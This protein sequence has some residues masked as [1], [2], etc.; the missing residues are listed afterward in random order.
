MSSS[1]TGLLAILFRMREGLGHFF[2]QSWRTDLEKCQMLCLLFSDQEYLSMGDRVS[3]R[4]RKEPGDKFNCESVC[5]RE[6]ARERA[7]A[8]ECVCVCVQVIF[9]RQI[10]RNSIE[11]DAKQTYFS[12]D[13]NFLTASIDHKHNFV[14]RSV[15]L[16]FY[17]DKSTRMGV[18]LTNKLMWVYKKYLFQ[19]F[20]FCSFNFRS[21][22]FF[23]N[24]FLVRHDAI[25][26]IDHGKSAASS[27]WDYPTMYIHPA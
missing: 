11:S 19:C 1:R 5:E 17:Y 3:L 22:I 2:I 26:C 27:I 8:R 6:S 24:L 21:F 7:F 9:G 13:F 14:N 15:F 10:W 23:R 18:N 25:G 4:W 12:I 16:S 20:D